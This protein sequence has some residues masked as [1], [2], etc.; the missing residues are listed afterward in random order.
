MLSAH[1]HEE[2]AVLDDPSGL[3]LERG[4]PVVPGALLVEVARIVYFDVIE[5]D[6]VLEQLLLEVRGRLSDGRRGEPSSA[7][8]RR[9][10]VEGGP[11]NNE[12]RIL[13]T[14]NRIR[15]PQHSAAWHNYTRMIF[16]RPIA[17]MY[18]MSSPGLRVSLNSSGMGRWN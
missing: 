6:A 12:L 3:L 10:P 8:E 4:D 18:M 2:L 5:R 7:P 11:W 9:S 1:G 15:E 16:L 14:I 17:T 13:V